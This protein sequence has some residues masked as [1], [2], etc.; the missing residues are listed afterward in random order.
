MSKQALRRTANE[1]VTQVER[2]RRDPMGVYHN[3]HEP[4]PDRGHRVERA[5][6][7]AQLDGDDIDDRGLR[8]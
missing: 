8:S 6:S 1:V 5:K 7:L 3:H 2:Y 4:Q